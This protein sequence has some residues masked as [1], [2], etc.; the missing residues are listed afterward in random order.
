LRLALIDCNTVQVIL[1][2][3][4]AARDKRLDGDVKEDIAYDR[5]TDDAYDEGIV[6][7]PSLLT[8]LLSAIY[9]A[10]F[11]APLCAVIAV[12]IGYQMTLAPHIRNNAFSWGLM[13]GV[14]GGGRLSHPEQIGRDMS[15][16][17]HVRP[18]LTVDEMAIIQER[19]MYAE[20]QFWMPP[21]SFDQ[22][23][24][25]F[26]THAAV[27]GSFRPPDLFYQGVVFGISD[28]NP[29]DLEYTRGNIESHKIE[30][31]NLHADLLSM[32]PR[33]TSV[34]MRTSHYNVTDWRETG[35][36]VYFSYK[37]LEKEGW[38]SSDR[39][40]PWKR[41]L[42][43]MLS[44]ARS[45]RQVYL[46]VWY[47]HTFGANDDPSDPFLHQNIIQQIIP[48][49]TGLHGIKS[50][51]VVWMT[52]LN[53]SDPDPKT[54]GHMSRGANDSSRKPFPTLKD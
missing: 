9:D 12:L 35:Y 45:Y 27:H 46:V 31:E 47:P 11:A 50:T 28:Q 53:Q 34:M 30:G 33:P 44:V 51:C 29:H 38:I 32:Q 20:S 25:R 21:P 39:T 10:R 13:G 41:V 6:E 19:I 1:M 26:Q 22:V 18:V 14:G 43:E 17:K 5:E 37:D 36:A 23:R 4:L 48:T 8:D 42:E 2:A 40:Q 52:T 16:L 54:W 15:S 7:V 24:L 49:R 3:A